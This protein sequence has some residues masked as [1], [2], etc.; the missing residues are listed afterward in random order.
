MFFIVV[1]LF[2]TFFLVLANEKI[3]IGYLVSQSAENLENKQQLCRAKE[4]L[5]IKLM[6]IF[7]KRLRIFLTL[8]CGAAANK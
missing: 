3:K 4:K 5:K 6:I 1:E 8:L 7:C 2:K